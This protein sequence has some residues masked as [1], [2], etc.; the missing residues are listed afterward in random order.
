[1]AGLGRGNPGAERLVSAD[2]QG[3]LGF[4]LWL[5]LGSWSQAGSGGGTVP[6]E[7]EGCRCWGF[8]PLPVCPPPH[9]RP[10]D[11]SCCYRPD[12]RFSAPLRSP[13]F[14]LFESGGR[15]W[16]AP[17]EVGA[18]W[19][20][21]R[22]HGGAVGSGSR[23]PGPAARLQEGSGSILGAGRGARACPDAELPP[24]S[25]PGARGGSSVALQQDGF[26]RGNAGG[27]R[28]ASRGG[29]RAWALRVAGF[30]RRHSLRPSRRGPPDQRGEKRTFCSLIL[31]VPAPRL[32]H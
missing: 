26:G 27:G 25:G 31:A 12:P 30:G 15:V 19:G 21:R 5:Q 10:G 28:H 11:R 13:C 8:L 18:R 20:L 7:G 3:G 2:L 22:P 29:P 14:S 32:S 9:S 24:P 6:P 1:M 23:V 4:F 17:R 16:S